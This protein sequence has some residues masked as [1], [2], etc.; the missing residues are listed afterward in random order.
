[1]REAPEKLHNH[2][3]HY[4]RTQGEHRAVSKRGL[5]F[6]FGASGPRANRCHRAGAKGGHGARDA[7]REDVIS[8]LFQELLQF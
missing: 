5:G 6:R 1:L 3:V 8:V 4:E 7:A 2:G